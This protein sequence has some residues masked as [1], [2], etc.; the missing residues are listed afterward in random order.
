MN[1]TP[2]YDFDWKRLADMPVGKWEP[3]SVVID[4]KLYVLGGY[5]SLIKSKKKLHVFDPAAGTH[6]TWTKLQDMPSET[7]HVNLAPDGA[8]FWFAGGMKDMRRDKKIKD[9]IIDET[10]HF[11]LILDRY[12]AGPLLPGPR[13]GG[14][15]AR[16]GD[17]LHYISGLMADRDTD[18]SDH[19]VLDLA[20][21]KKNRTGTWQQLAPLPLARNQLSVVVLDNKI[22]VIGGQLNHDLQQLDQSHVDIYDP[23]TDSWRDGPAL[24][25]GHSHS[26]GA[27]FVH[28]QRIWMVGGHTTPKGGDKGLCD[29]VITMGVGEE[30]EITGKLPK[31]ISSPASKVIN[32]KLY[33]AGGWD[34][35]M[36]EATPERDYWADRQVSSPEVWVADLPARTG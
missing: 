10:W 6:G 36:T 14:G 34:R 15:L 8:G 20:Q 27:T 31:G 3:A 16:V 22:Y 28:D 26:E 12:T 13:A 32:S 2:I 4:D 7:T 11:D 30:W 29:N 25:Y 21:W 23:I 35:R 18:S 1:G 9:H 24:P 17:N 33:V 5:E 19:W